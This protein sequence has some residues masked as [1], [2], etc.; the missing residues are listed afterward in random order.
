MTEENISQPR[1]EQEKK[2]GKED[3]HQMFFRRD[4]PEVCKIISRFQ[5]FFYIVRQKKPSSTK[6]GKENL[7]VC[8]MEVGRLVGEVIHIR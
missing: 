3:G 7:Q 2:I 6:V 1:E 4:Q 8:K 5:V